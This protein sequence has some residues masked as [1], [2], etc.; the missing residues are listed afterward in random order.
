MITTTKTLLFWRLLITLVLLFVGFPLDFALAED[1]GKELYLNRCSGCHGE[2]GEGRSALPLNK[3]GFLVTVE[4]DY[5][6]RSILFGR[7]LSGCPSLEN[8]LT[9]TEIVKIARF[10][11]SWQRGK[12]L[13][14]SAHTVAAADSKRG[15]ELFP[16]C[17]GCHGLE[18]EGAM[19][20]PLFDMGLLKSLSDSDLRRTIVYG[21]PGT[22]MRGFLKG[23]KGSLGTMSNAD[24]DKLIAYIRFRQF[25]LE[26]KN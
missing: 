1:N 2:E 17:G 26:E 18:G 3:E 23:A 12:L 4:L 14:V 20:P 9:E 7:P 15:R 8:I 11:K 25:A 10:I 21:R 6:T 13:P 5:I 22:P 24:V 16:L 19:G